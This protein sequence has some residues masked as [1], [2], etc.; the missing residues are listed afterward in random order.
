[1]TNIVTNTRK[2]EKLIRIVGL[3]MCLVFTAVVSTAQIGPVPHPARQKAATVSYPAKT[4]AGKNAANK[5]EAAL[6][7]KEAKE[8]ESFVGAKEVGPCDSATI[9]FGATAQGVVALRICTVSVTTAG[10]PIV[11]I[12]IK[13]GNGADPSPLFKSEKSDEDKS[14]AATAPAKDVPTG[15]CTILIGFLPNEKSNVTGTMTVQF[16][17]GPAQSF[18][19]K[20]TGTE[21]ASCLS[22]T[23]AWLP[24]NKGFDQGGLYP[25]LA[26]NIPPNLA[27]AVYKDFGDPIRKSV[28]NCFY[29]TNGLSSYFNQLQSIYNSASGSTTVNAQIG[30]LNFL[31]G[32]QVTVGTNPQ[33]ASSNATAST[34]S[35]GTTTGGVPTLSATAASQAAQNILNGGT[36]F[37]SDIFPI[38]SKQSNG[39]IYLAAQAKEGVDI[40][41]FNNNSITLSNPSTHT[42]VGLQGY[43]QYSSSNTATNS[44]DPAGS[45]FLS[46]MYGYSLMNHSY[47]VQNG[48]GGRVNSQ[49]AQVG[50]GILISGVAKIAVYRGFGPSQRYIDSSTTATT[51]VNDFNKWSVA[52]AYQSS[53]K[54]K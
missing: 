5:E 20:G 44:T 23:H 52:I 50:A 33:I 3:I 11:S 12:D 51:T 29:S 2:A 34:P 1:V 35:T 39:L 40:Q 9:D 37:G 7:E 13:D 45:I 22:P 27:L 30:S 53:G 46:A 16:L 36:I 54:S 24:L 14:C 42:F 18:T 32:M 21:A 19:L 31:N 43:L 41:K 26:A 47:S 8:Q 15:K 28:I 17:D 6:Q 38:L 49:I 48:F 25:L 4:G 10:N